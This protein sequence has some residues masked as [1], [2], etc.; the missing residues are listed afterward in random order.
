MPLPLL[1]HQLSN[2]EQIEILRNEIDQ[3]EEEL[4]KT[5]SRIR[6]VLYQIEKQRFL[7][8]VHVVF[9]QGRLLPESE[10]LTELNTTRETL[11]RRAASATM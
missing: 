9:Q 2:F 6:D 5:E 8:T 10:S 4:K 7:T 11:L 3:F 1:T